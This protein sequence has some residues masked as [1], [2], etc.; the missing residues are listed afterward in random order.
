MNF[1]N[2]C[3]INETMRSTDVSTEGVGIL[4]GED[5][6]QVFSEEFLFSTSGYANFTVTPGQVFI[7]ELPYLLLTEEGALV[8]ESHQDQADWTLGALA[9]LMT[10][11]VCEATVRDL[12]DIQRNQPEK[13]HRRWL[14]TAIALTLII[15]KIYL[16]S[17]CWRRPLLDFASRYSWRKNR[18]TPRVPDRKPFVL[19]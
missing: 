7:S 14:I 5:N 9:S 15:P 3:R 16:T 12:T 11:G 8:L 13:R 6:C 17:N 18:V 19:W 1:T 4:F 2:T 10:R